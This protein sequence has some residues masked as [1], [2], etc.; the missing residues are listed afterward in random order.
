[1]RLICSFSQCFKLFDRED[2]D[3]LFALARH[4]LWPFV[5]GPPK[6]FTEASLGGLE[7]PGSDRP[8]PGLISRFHSFS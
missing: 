8:L 2:H 3:L 6:E 4:N 5:A 1:M 7:L